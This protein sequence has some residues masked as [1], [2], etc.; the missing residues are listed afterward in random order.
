MNA[1][2][3]WALLGASIGVMAG[4]LTNGAK[5]GD[6]MSFEEKQVGNWTVKCGGDDET[7]KLTHCSMKS[8]YR[9]KGKN[10]K[11]A[12]SKEVTMG[13]ALGSNGKGW[14]SI[15]GDGWDKPKLVEG[16]KFK[17]KV[18]FDKNPFS[19]RWIYQGGGL[20]FSGFFDG[21]TKFLANAGNA[22]GLYLKIGNKVM[23]GLNL[24]GSAKAANVLATMYIKYYKAT[25]TNNNDFQVNP[26]NDYSFGE[27]ENTVNSF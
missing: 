10:A 4:A 9:M 13:F 12:G 6:Y 18:K 14:I 7:S 19:G 15:Q 5:A 17:G 21:M 1:I 16:A 8:L 20:F 25:I 23:P 22:K 26:K 3:K 27:G 11:K 2:M 24:S